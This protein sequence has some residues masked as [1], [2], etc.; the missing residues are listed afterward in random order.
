MELFGEI[1]SGLYDS[2]DDRFDLVMADRVV[3]DLDGA[4]MQSMAEYWERFPNASV[5]QGVF[6]LEWG[7]TVERL[8][9][10]NYEADAWQIGV[11]LIDNPDNAIWFVRV[12]DEYWAILTLHVLLGVL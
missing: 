8:V 2:S 12:V 1:R 7:S 3:I 9:L 6:H 10:V 4:G 5:H 11:Y